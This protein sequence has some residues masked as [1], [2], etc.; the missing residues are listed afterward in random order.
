MLALCLLSQLCYTSLGDKA[1]P[2]GVPP[3]LPTVE[4]AFSQDDWSQFIY[5]RFDYIAKD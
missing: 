1:A 5:N 4:V 2:A 3:E